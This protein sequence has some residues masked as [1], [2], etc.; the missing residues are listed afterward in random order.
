MVLVNV[1]VQVEN[2]TAEDL[3]FEFHTP[4]VG[5]IGGR[6]PETMEST[7][8]HGNFLVSRFSVVAVQ[9]YIWYVCITFVYICFYRLT[10]IQM[11][12]R[13]K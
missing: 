13:V 10:P 7:G 9:E 8:G 3:Q 6:M 12:S 1:Q 4:D 5:K 2:N 11:E